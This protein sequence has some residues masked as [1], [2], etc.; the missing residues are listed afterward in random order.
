MSIGSRAVKFK[1]TR[2]G[3]PS[4]GVGMAKFGPNGPQLELPSSK[5]GPHELATAPSH[6]IVPAKGDETP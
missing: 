6:V 2:M 1:V 4:L 3:W 5:Q